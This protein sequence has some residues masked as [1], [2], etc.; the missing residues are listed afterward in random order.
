MLKI[1]WLKVNRFR[2]VSRGI[3]LNFNDRYNMLLGQNATG[4][5]T[6]LNLVAAA[7]RCDFGEFEDEPFDIEYRLELTDASIEVRVRNETVDPPDDSSTTGSS[8]SNQ[9]EPTVARLSRF[10]FSRRCAF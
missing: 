5:T 1:R 3:Q 6:L 9:P 7:C 10:R 8:I 2:S 4:K